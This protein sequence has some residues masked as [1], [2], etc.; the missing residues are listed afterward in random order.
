MSE[1]IIIVSGKR[2][3]FYN[4]N[5]IIGS[6]TNGS[7]SVVIKKGHRRIFINTNTYFMANVIDYEKS[8]NGNIYLLVC[9]VEFIV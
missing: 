2:Y 8:S 1:P 9:D 7:V 3:K 4:V 5:G 6:T